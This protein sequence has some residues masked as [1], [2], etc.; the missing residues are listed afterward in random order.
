MD[1][2]YEQLSNHHVQQVTTALSKN[3]ASR[4]MMCSVLKVSPQELEKLFSPI[5]QGSI[6]Y[7]Y[8]AKDL[9]T[10]DVIGAIICND[11]AYF[12]E[13]HPMEQFSHELQAIMNLLST[14]E[15]NFV[16]RH[17][18]QIKKNFYLYQY[19]IYVDEMFQHRGIASN[20]YKL[21]EDLAHKKR[22]KRIVTIPTG[23]ATQHLCLNHFGYKQQEEILYH[24][25]RYK[26][27]PVFPIADPP[28][29][30]LTTKDL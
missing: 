4:E 2:A 17:A 8:I 30:I 7:S 28:S 19:V 5:V 23:K 25:F 10:N 18:S 9:K 16:K 13:S 20:L 6:D 11:F 12:L 14:L 29:C 22:F 26:G 1:I 15:E 3:F 21:S 27:K 24:D